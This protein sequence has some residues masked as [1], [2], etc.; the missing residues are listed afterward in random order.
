MEISQEGGVW[1]GEKQKCSK[2]RG[3]Y[4]YKYKGT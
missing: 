2:K 4:V 3:R 1:D